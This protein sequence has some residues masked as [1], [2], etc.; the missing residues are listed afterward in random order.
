M[1]PSGDELAGIVDMFGALTRDQLHR[2]VREAAFRAGEDVEESAVDAAITSA[3]AE[4]RLVGYDPDGEG[5]DRDPDPATAGEGEYLVVGPTAFPS[6]PEG[7]T[8][9]PHIMDVDR[10]APDREAA[11]EAVA[12]RF[13]AETARA[14]ERGDESRIERL[15]DV[16]YDIET[17]APVEMTPLRERLDDALA[18]G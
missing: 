5:G 2:A 9:L 13:R 7:A 6:P 4:Y 1:P 11:G 10:E 18:E 8:D 16:S 12:R 3:V 15:L 17:W 14:V